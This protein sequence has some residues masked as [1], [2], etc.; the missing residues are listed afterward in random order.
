ME[1]TNIMN[2]SIAKAEKGDTVEW[3]KEMEPNKV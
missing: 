3:M 2:A 1:K